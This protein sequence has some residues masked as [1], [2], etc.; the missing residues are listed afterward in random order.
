MKQDKLQRTV[1]PLE[2]IA[3]MH[4]RRT[5]ERI[6][7]IGARN[8]RPARGIVPL[9]IAVRKT[10][11]PERFGRQIV[12]RFHAEG[13]AGRHPVAIT[14]RETNTKNPIILLGIDFY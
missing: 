2:E 12:S 11:T 13:N 5:N 4:A 9:R 10:G 7:G 3:G 14:R 1:L 8:I 6:A